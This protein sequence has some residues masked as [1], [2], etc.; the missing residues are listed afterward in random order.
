[1]QAVLALGLSNA[2]VATI[3]ALMA[4]V[5]G[6]LTRRPA[7][8]H[9]LWLL[10]L[11]KLITPPVWSVPVAW[12][13][14]QD[15]T[16]QVTV[17][18]PEAIELPLPPEVSREVAEI[19]TDD[20]G[21]READA[22]AAAEPPL[23]S[24]WQFSPQTVLVG[25]WCTGTIGWLLLA[26]VRLVRFEKLASRARS[27]PQGVH[28]QAAGLAKTM[29]LSR[30]PDIRFVQGLLP[31]MVFG[32]FRAPRLL[33]PESLWHKLDKEQ[34]ETLLA[35][36]LAHVRRG[37]HW[38]RLLELLVTSLYWWHPITWW[39][40]HEL[41]E[42]EEACCDAWVIATLPG[43]ART[44][45]GALVTV[46]DFLSMAREPLPAEASGLGHMS[47]LKRRLSMILQR[48]APRSLSR[49]GVI[50]VLGLAL[51]VL[52]WVPRWAMGEPPA[53]QDTPASKFV[54]DA[55][56]DKRGFPVTVNEVDN[57]ERQK[58]QLQT[59]SEE[60]K[61]LQD[62]IAVRQAALKALGETVQQ[63][64]SN[65]LQPQRLIEVYNLKLNTPLA[66][67]GKQ[68]QQLDGQ[69]R[70]VVILRKE[71]DGKYKAEVIAP[72]TG[73][74]NRVRSLPAASRST[75]A[76]KGREFQALDSA[77]L[78]SDKA[79]DTGRR[80][81]ELEKKMDT[82]IRKLEAQHTDRPGY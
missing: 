54:N 34:R 24:L 63:Y 42:A 68:L 40:R 31:P 80:L 9:S 46:L 73:H 21:S 51:L 56:V 25:I 39:A 82:I 65:R 18:A 1:M 33:L 55:L 5:V 17:A 6:R 81:A 7:L 19:N 43:S 26:G 74:E 62:Q 50:G 71:Q 59:L 32:L 29:G 72:S 48:T 67:V 35:H 57:R 60:I 64:Q 52:P 69:D 10:V 23:L 70:I 58:A 15:H 27:A 77:T 36:E 22:V 2:L 12:P 30:C 41:R 8:T 49:G 11:L 13:T 38:V 3:L 16:E 75:L 61:I 47:N 14:T 28:Q 66:E 53:S 20:F 76:I 45:A 44:Y 79:Q 4:A 37:D 78:K